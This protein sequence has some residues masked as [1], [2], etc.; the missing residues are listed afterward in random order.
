MKT[1]CHM[2]GGCIRAFE[3]ETCG[4]QGQCSIVL[5]VLAEREACAD[6]ADE[7]ECHPNLL[8]L[9]SEDMNGAAHT[10]QHEA[11]ERIANAIRARD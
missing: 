4:D 5:A 6:L 8:P 10:G 1:A 11:A 7:W 9:A 3:D 2:E